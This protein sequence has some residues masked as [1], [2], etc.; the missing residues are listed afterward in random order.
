MWMMLGN[1][2]RLPAANKVEL[3]WLLLGG[4]LRNGARPQ[5]LWT[6]SRF[7]ARIPF[8]GPLDQVIPGDEASRWVNEL[9][10]LDM[11]P[12]DALAQV[13]IQ[14]CRRTGDRERDLPQEDP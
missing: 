5:S 14:L 7:G 2:E 6:L 1:F 11:E 3:G 10:S 9:L 12:T 13:M 4:I 8:Y